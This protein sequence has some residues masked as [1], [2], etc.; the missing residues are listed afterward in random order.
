ML[1][2]NGTAMPSPSAM[3]VTLEEIAGTPERSAAGGAVM[4]CRGSKRRIVLKWAW[5]TGQ[6][7]S[8]LLAAVEAR[9]FDATFPDPVS[10]AAR[11]VRCWCAARSMGV[12]RMR[13]GA[14]VWTEIEMEWRE[15]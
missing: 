6:Q 15:R 8:G 12:L 11:T 13:G 5:L 4:D 7:L 3:Q 9:F 14:P 10:G 1:K 2:I